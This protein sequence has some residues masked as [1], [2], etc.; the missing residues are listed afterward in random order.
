MTVSDKGGSRFFDAV[1]ARYDELVSSDPT[2]TWVRAAFQ[3]LVAET[4]APG[5]LLLD[6]G[7]GTGTDALWYAKRGYRVIAYDNS[8]MMIEQLKAKCLTQIE[9]EEIVPYHADYEEFL[10]QELRPCPVA[11]VS[12]F[13]ALSAISDLPR[14]FAAWAG[15]VA[16]SGHVIVSMLNPFFWRNMLRRSWLKDCIRSMGTGM[17][18]RTCEDRPDIYGYLPS[19][20]AAAASSHFV[21]MGEAGVGA[22]TSGSKTHQAWSAPKTAAGRLERRFWKTRTV[23][24]FGQFIF[25]VFQRPA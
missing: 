21:K 10:E 14:L 4:V 6:F 19:S 23:R 11:I 24:T 20:V 7:C 16:P 25:I 2:H 15:R 5:G 17:I 13:A 9:S 1:A 12:N 8:A 18:V 22:L 3:S